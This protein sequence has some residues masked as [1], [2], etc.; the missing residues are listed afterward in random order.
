MKLHEKPGGAAGS[1]IRVD[2]QCCGSGQI[3]PIGCIKYK[4]HKKMHARGIIYKGQ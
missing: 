3:K 1:G 4:T 2:G